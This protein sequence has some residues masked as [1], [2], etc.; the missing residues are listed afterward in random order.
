MNWNRIKCAALGW[1]VWR[2]DD[3]A[4]SRIFGA[5]TCRRCGT[6]DVGWSLPPMP[7]MLTC[8]PDHTTD[9]KAMNLSDRITIADAVDIVYIDGHP[10]SGAALDFF[11]IPG[12][13]GHWFR[14][15]STDP[16]CAITVSVRTD[17]V[18][19]GDAAQPVA[20]ALTE[21][22]IWDVIEQCIKD[23]VTNG[24]LSVNAARAALAEIEAARGQ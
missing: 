8:A 2:T 7:P 6:K 20:R 24:K 10:F 22:S 1:H 4:E 15:Q 9:D 14:V 16:G 21:S 12:P 23:G 19:S 11:T 13:D 5:R 17:P 18:P 3:G